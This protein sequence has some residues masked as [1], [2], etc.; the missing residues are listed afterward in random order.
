MDACIYDGKEFIGKFIDKGQGAIDEL[1]MSYIIAK[2]QI[3]LT[4]LDYNRYNCLPQFYAWDAKII[5]FGIKLWDN[6]LLQVL[7][8]AWREYYLEAMNITPSLSSEC[9]KLLD[10]PGDYVRRKLDE[11]RWHEFFRE[12]GFQPPALLR[13]DYDF[14][15]EW[16][17]MWYTE[18]VYYEFKF[19]QYFYDGYMIGFWIKNRD[20]LSDKGIR[21]KI[22]ELNARNPAVFKLREDHR[23][24][25][26][27]SEK[28]NAQEI[29]K[30][31][32]YFYATTMELLARF[33]I[34]PEAPR[35]GAA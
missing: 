14:E 28:R 29:V 34:V 1:M 9:V 26:I 18:D 4:V 5:H 15:N 16:M 17:I 27:F 35:K 19:E 32:E 25:Y 2:N 11:K 7:F 33:R 22:K 12:T 20:M 10:E 6:P 23:G 31:F 30:L 13:L 8:P 24:M 3:P 21:E